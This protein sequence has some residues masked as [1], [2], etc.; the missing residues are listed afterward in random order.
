MQT[1]LPY[2]D[3]KECA[4]SLDYKRLGKQRLE[5]KQ[6]LDALNPGSNS[7]W[8][9]HPA[10]KMWKG[11]EGSLRYYMNCILDEW[12]SR[13][14]KNTIPHNSDFSEVIPDWINDR[15]VYSHRANL[16][17]KLPGH[18]NWEGVDVNAPYWWPTGLKD[19]KMNELMMEYYR[20]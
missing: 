4:K 10:V 11:Y 3:F 5:C 18:Y 7:R 1:F 20:E 16:M 6:I 17:R 14:Y 13:G 12:I 15:L 8:R 2:K 19:K 9:N